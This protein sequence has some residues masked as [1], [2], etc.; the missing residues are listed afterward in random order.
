MKIVVEIW[1]RTCVDALIFKKII[2]GELIA[3][4]TFDEYTSESS[5]ALYYDTNLNSTCLSI[6]PFYILFYIYVDFL[7]FFLINVTSFYDA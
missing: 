6:S 5:I 2:I 7:S 1:G 3:R 4:H